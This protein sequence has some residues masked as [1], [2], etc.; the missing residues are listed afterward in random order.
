M[1]AIVLL[2]TFTFVGAFIAWTWK[3]ESDNIKN[4]FGL[5]DPNSLY[6]QKSIVEDIDCWLRPERANYYQQMRSE[7]ALKAFQGQD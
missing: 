2:L 7:R 6:G 1:K 4:L 3:T 5:G